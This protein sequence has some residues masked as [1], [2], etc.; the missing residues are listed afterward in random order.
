MCTLGWYFR[1]PQTVNTRAHMRF[2][3][4]PVFSERLEYHIF[5]TANNFVFVRIN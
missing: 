1:I 4:H 3:F 5:L 2:G